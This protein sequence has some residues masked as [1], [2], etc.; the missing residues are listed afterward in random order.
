[1]SD[2]DVHNVPLLVTDQYGKFIPGADGYAQVVAQVQI[3][4]NV[5]GNVVGTEGNPFVLSGV[6]GG[7]DLANLALPSGLPALPAG[8]SYKTVTVGTNHAF[9]NDIAHHAAPNIID[10]DHNPATPKVAQIADDDRLDYNSDGGADAADVAA[11]ADD[12]TDANSDDVIDVLDLADVN[13]DGIIDAKDLV[14]DDR[15]PLT[16]DDEMLNA[17]F[18][19]GDGRGNENIALTAVHTMF[20]SEHN[21]IVEANKATILSI[22]RSRVHQ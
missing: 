2:F 16:Y 14:A 6:A 21:R 4:D 22:R 20:H 17:H 11:L 9:L 3:I 19:T 18:V 15:N 1:M 13:L 5:T 10:H 8:Q 12:L 7:L